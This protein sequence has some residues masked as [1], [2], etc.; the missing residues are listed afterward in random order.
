MRL[1]LLFLTA[2]T[3]FADDSSRILRIDHYVQVKSTAPGMNGQMGQ[4]YVREVAKA[5][6]VLRGGAPADRVVLFIHGAGTPSHVAFD[7]PHEGY[8]WM[9]YL[10]NAGF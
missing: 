7:V 5:G 8:S 9:E 10:A 6:G 2:S 4:I 1:L 3:L